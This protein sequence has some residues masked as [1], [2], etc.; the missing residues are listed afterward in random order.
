MFEV[1]RGGENMDNLVAD[2]FKIFGNEV[3]EF[4]YIRKCVSEKEKAAA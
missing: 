3:L 4:K 1:R 2:D